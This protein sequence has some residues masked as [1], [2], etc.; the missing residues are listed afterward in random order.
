M[1]RLLCGCSPSNMRISFESPSCIHKW[2][3]LWQ[4]FRIC[5]P[6][7]S[8][9]KRSANLRLHGEL[10]GEELLQRFCLGHV[11]RL[12]CHLCSATLGGNVCRSSWWHLWS[13][14]GSGDHRDRHVMRYGWTR[15]TS[16]TSTLGRWQS[17]RRVGSLAF[18]LPSLGTRTVHRWWDWVCL[19]L[20][21]GGLG[22]GIDRPLLVLHNNDIEFRLLDS[23]A[24]DLGVW[25][26]SRWRKDAGL[27]MA[28]AFYHGPDTWC[29]RCVGA[30]VSPQ[31]VRTVWR[32]PPKWCFERKRNRRGGIQPAANEK[33]HQTAIKRVCL[34][35]HLGGIHWY[36]RCALLCRFPIWWHGLDKFLL[37]EAWCPS[38]LCDVG[39][40]LPESSSNHS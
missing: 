29:G 3:A 13:Q 38:Q 34:Y 14:V 20:H 7:W 18:V 40:S 16:N 30:L 15:L 33:I 26:P 1:S 19:H 4:C 6:D 39:W 32:G 36:W 37:E 10:H 22:F 5:G 17:H 9:I 12:H 31:G 11:V 21:F 23:S 2:S 35:T 24:C 27:G 28:F 8:R 25:E